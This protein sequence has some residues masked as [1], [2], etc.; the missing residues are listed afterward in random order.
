M[1]TGLLEKLRSYEATSEGAGPKLFNMANI[2]LNDSSVLTRPRFKMSSGEV[3]SLVHIEQTSEHTVTLEGVTEEGLRAVKHV[4]F[5]KPWYRC[6]CTIEDVE[7]GVEV[8]D[9]DIENFLISTQ[10]N[11][12]EA[13]K[14]LLIEELDEGIEQARIMYYRN[15]SHAEFKMGRVYD[16]VNCET[17]KML[18]TKLMRC[19]ESDLCMVGGML[20]TGSEAE[21]G[22]LYLY[23]LGKE[24]IKEND[25]GNS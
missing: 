23:Q 21:V 9:D 12:H 1:L 13:Y 18:V 6:S 22:T 10:E 5:G 17:K 24:Y 11:I 4:F 7:D 15:N 16:V 3:I 20:I 19:K 25:D 8:M 2:Y 14:E